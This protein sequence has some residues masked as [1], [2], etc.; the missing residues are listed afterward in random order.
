MIISYSCHVLQC[1]LVTLSWR[2][3]D[4]TSPITTSLLHLM[5]AK[6]VPSIKELERNVDQNAG[7]VRGVCWKNV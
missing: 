6:K 7:H 1:L 4:E 5:V 3:M 2:E